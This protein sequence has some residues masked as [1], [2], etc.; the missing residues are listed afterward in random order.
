MK[1]LY[2][3]LLA[4]VGS[5]SFGQTFYSENMGTPAG[6]T[7]I[8]LNVFQNTTPIVYSGTADV[9]ATA[10]SSG[11]NGATGGGNVFINAIDEYFQ[12]DGLNSSAYNTADLQLAFG[13]NT[14]SPITN[15]LIVEVSTDATVWTPI[16]YTPSATGWTLTTISGGVIPSS[17]T[18]SIRFKS[19]STSQFRLDDIKLS[20][21][22]ASCTLAL[23]NVTAVCD[24]FNFGPDTYTA[25]I[26]FTG[27]GNAVYSLVPNAGTIGGDDPSTNATG[28]IVI[29]GIPEGTAL[30][31]AVT[32]GTCNTSVGVNSPECKP[33][34]TLPFSDAFPYAVDSALGSQEK[35]TNLTA[36]TDL[37][38]GAAGSLNYP[39]TSPAGN[40]ITFSGTG[41]DSFSP[42][43]PTTSGTVYASFMINVTDMALLTTD[44]SETYFAILSDASR[45][46][47]ARLFLKKNGTQYQLGFDAPST[48]TNYDATLRNVGEVVFVVMGYDFNT[49]TL[50]AWFNPDLTTLN[51]ATPANLTATPVTA[52]TELGGFVIR[53][54]ADN[55]TPTM[56][57]DELRIATTIPNSLG[58]AQN[59]ITG[60]K[61]YPNP[62][63]NGTLFIDTKANAEK[64]IVIYD[65]LGKQVFNTT[66][67]NN[68]INVAS[69][70]GGVYILKITEAGKTATSK[71]VIK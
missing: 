49:N 69:L 21:V 8:A 20:S 51:A 28:N 24:G 16:T 2:I 46:F 36:G 66:T 65:V 40:S 25:T 6:T 44:L 14:P 38:V 23:G 1:K 55:K 34:N 15:V 53:Q 11:Y 56:I 12:I 70:K 17:A 54:D 33:V 4:V 31:V 3:L 30:T 7:A 60:L 42:F 9:R 58:V 35:W 26:P 64:N 62:V 67:A 29:N 32:G 52:I 71:L 27:G 61:V 45:S 63:T 50:S 19:T 68:A 22:S 18:L 47:K 59:E 13:I 41:I 43:T 48:T 10:V 39:N 57:M 5:A 37:I